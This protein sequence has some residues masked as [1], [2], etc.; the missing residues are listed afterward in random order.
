MTQRA[1]AHKTRNLMFEV[2]GQVDQNGVLVPDPE[3]YTIDGITIAYQA[4]LTGEG[5]F[6]LT[7]TQALIDAG[8]FDTFGWFEAQ[9]VDGNGK[10]CIP[11]PALVPFPPTASPITFNV[12]WTQANTTGSVPPIG[13]ALTAVSPTAM[14]VSGWY[15]TSGVSPNNFNSP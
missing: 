4:G 12:I 3:S 9:G 2:F 1:A 14:R 5:V 8:I 11:Y 6:T 15:G 13:V 10:F 7:A